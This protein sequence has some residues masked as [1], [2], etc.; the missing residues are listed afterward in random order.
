MIGQSQGRVGDQALAMLPVA[1]CRSLRCSNPAEHQHG[2]QK[3]TVPIQSL[4]THQLT[5]L[6]LIAA[7]TSVSCSASMSPCKTTAWADLYAEQR[8]VRVKNCIS[9]VPR[10]GTGLCVTHGVQHNA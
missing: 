9:N 8:H 10:I 3:Q 1:A 6:L 4:A 5:H 7:Y 2:R